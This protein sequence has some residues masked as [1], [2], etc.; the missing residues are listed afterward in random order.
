MMTVNDGFR[1]INK[2]ETLLT[3][4]ARVIIYDNPMFIVQAT[5]EQ[6]LVLRIHFYI[7]TKQATLNE[8]V[9]C[10]FLSIYLLSKL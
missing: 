8:D 2:L 3:D 4:D 10:I 1:V 5:D 9:N 6:L 7:L